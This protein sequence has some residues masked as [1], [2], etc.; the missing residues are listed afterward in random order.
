L[1]GP[2]LFD[3]MGHDPGNSI[4]DGASIRSTVAAWGPNNPSYWTKLL[5]TA[6]PM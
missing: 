3:D 4:Q 5:V 2:H 6:N 1:P